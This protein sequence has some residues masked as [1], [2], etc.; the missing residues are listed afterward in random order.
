MKK[1]AV[2]DLI[3]QFKSGVAKGYVMYDKMQFEEL[4]DKPY[5]SVIMTRIDGLEKKY[6]EVR[7]TYSDF[8]ISG[9][10][11]RSK[12]GAGTEYKHHDHPMKLSTIMKG[13]RSVFGSKRFRMMIQAAR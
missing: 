4:N 3:S 11:Q 12:S 8:V 1:S 2:K 9:W 7:Y 6:G 10:D 13:E 5:V